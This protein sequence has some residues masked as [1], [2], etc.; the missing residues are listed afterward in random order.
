MWKVSYTHLKGYGVSRKF[1][2]KKEA[3]EFI[4][5]N[6]MVCRLP[7]C[8]LTFESDYRAPTLSQLHDLAFGIGHMFID[9][10]ITD[11]EFTWQWNLAG[12]MTNRHLAEVHRIF[13]P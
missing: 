11:P 2:T 4:D 9:G 1:A 5:V 8:S 7:N 12:A 6:A 3:Q 10:T 13:Q